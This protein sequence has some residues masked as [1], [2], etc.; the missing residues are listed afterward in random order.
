MYQQR[1]QGK[2][3]KNISVTLTRTVPVEDGSEFKRL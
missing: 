2:V 1:H 3:P